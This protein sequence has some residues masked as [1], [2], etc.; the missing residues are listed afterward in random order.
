VILVEINT[1]SRLS[2]EFANLLDLLRALFID[3]YIVNTRESFKVSVGLNFSGIER[4]VVPFLA[5]G[6]IRDGIT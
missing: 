5:G 3:E 2:F 4:S 6:Q 1:W